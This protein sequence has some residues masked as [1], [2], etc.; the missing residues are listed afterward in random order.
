MFT[1][2]Y[3]WT[4]RA[5]KYFRVCFYFTSWLSFTCGY[6]KGEMGRLG[7]ILDLHDLWFV[8]VPDVASSFVFMS[9]FANWQALNNTNDV[10]QLSVPYV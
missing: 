3:F 7:I 1:S 2:A 5:V 4:P 10:G 8:T 6:G 9:K